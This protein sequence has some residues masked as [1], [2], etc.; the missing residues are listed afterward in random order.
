MFWHGAFYVF[1]SPHIFQSIISETNNLWGSS[2]FSKYFKFYVD[3][4]NAE[5]N[6]ENIFTDFEIIAFEL[7]AL[8]TR[9]YWHRILFI[10]DQYVN[11]M[12]QDFRYY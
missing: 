3:S 2:F 4:Q 10:S 6:W 11:K 5:K 7:F 9:F 1:E 12:S 8:D